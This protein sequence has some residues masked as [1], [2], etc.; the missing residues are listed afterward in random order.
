[1]KKF[2][3]LI[4][5]VLM[6]S[7]V[8]FAQAPKVKPKAPP[9]KFM[10][11]IVSKGL[12]LKDDPSPAAKL[13]LKTDSVIFIPKNFYIQSVEDNT[14]QQDSIGFVLQPKSGKQQKLIFEG[15]IAEG[16]K[17]YY[18]S[19]IKQDTTLYP[20]IVSIKKF[21][22]TEQ[23]EQFYDKGTIEYALEFISNYKGKRMPV[24]SYSG[25][26]YLNTFLGK[27]KSY[28]SL[29]AYRESDYLQHV[30]EQMGKAINEIPDFAKGVKINVTITDNNESPDTIYFRDSRMLDWSDYRN[31]GSNDND[32]YS[33]IMI[34]Y[35]VDAD[36]KD[37]YLNFNI[38][39]ATAFIPSESFAG[40]NIRSAT[41]L[42]HE[43]YRF[44]LAHVYTLRLAKKF[45]GLSLT[46]ENARQEISKAYNETYKMLMA[47]L[48]EYDSQTGYSKK[49]KEQANWED[50][51]NTAMQEE[52]NN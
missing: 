12:N 44:K 21:L 10:K 48:K 34:P 40:S 18:H 16:F 13:H 8:S 11:D 38:N 20:M 15:G 24:S 28:D 42:N 23:R 52:L 32:L 35:E 17:Q 7:T 2:L 37:Q 14:G 1:M 30:D 26:G 36:Y 43:F 25:G 5:S 3:F 49:K 22:I 41:L 46:K 51:I 45:K 31:T 6:F 27:K 39:I 33:G 29:F 47:E 19:A 9:A 4:S 50:K